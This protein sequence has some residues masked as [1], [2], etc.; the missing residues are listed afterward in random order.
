MFRLLRALFATYR[1]L[2]AL[3]MAFRK[4]A[5]RAR[6]KDLQM[7]AG[8]WTIRAEAEAQGQRGT[9]GQGSGPVRQATPQAEW[10]AG[11]VVQ[12]SGANIH[13]ALWRSRDSTG[14]FVSVLRLD[15]YPPFPSASECRPEAAPVDCS[16][17][18]R[19]R[20]TFSATL[21]MWRPMIQQRNCGNRESLCYGMFSRRIR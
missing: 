21:A 9:V 16:V 17:E 5:G 13:Y 14:Y 7:A 15:G 20:R 19:Y 1:G 10:P 18:K 8:E 11:N 6:S 12:P 2:T 4:A 3:R